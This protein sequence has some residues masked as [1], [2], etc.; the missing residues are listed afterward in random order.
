LAVAAEKYM[1]TENP[2]KKNLAGHNPAV[3]NNSTVA[4]FFSGG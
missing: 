4:R 2:L 3:K 1:A